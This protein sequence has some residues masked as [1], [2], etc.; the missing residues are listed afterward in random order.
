[1]DGNGK[2]PAPLRKGEARLYLASVRGL[3]DPAEDG[4][5][6]ALLTHSRQEQLLRLM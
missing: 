4:R 3:P 2:A 5:P 6:A 1:M